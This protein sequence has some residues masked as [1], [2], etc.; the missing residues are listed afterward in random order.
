MFPFMLEA[1]RDWR[2]RRMRRV[3][4]GSA[5]AM[6]LVGGATLVQPLPLALC[7]VVV[8]I[9]LGWKEGSSRPPDM[10]ARSLI[11]AFSRR[12]REIVAGKSLSALAAW[13]FAAL[14]VSPPLAL[15]DIA[16]G[17]GA[18]ALAAC[19]LSWLAAY[20]VSFSAAFLSSLVFSKSDGLP[21]LLLLALWLG[22]AF[23]SPTWA[24]SNP[25]VQV[26]NILKAE[27]G[28]AP[29]L[30]MG[31]CVLVSAALLSATAWLFS[32]LRRGRRA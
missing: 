4:V 17:L 28:A 11:L 9:F 5:V 3:A 16:W 24:G 19:F 2:E 15:A 8:F 31:A 27:G 30:G 12:P 10:D 26:W 32:F 6:A 29:F 21:G 1:L 18:G 22:S 23:F 14:V 25:F 13:A 7:A 20:L